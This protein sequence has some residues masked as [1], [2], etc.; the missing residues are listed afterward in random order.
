MKQIVST[1]VLE[2]L[3]RYDSCTLSNAIE[4]LRRAAARRE[5]THP[6]SAMWVRPSSRRCSVAI[7][8]PATLSRTTDPRRELHEFSRATGILRSTIASNCFS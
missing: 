8:A 3:K 6:M 7:R 2:Q 1:D 5:V 4:V